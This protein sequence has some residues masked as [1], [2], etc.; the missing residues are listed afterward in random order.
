MHE[1]EKKIE[2]EIRRKRRNNIIIKDWKEKEGGNV[3]L[4]ENVENIFKENIHRE[5]K[6]LRHKKLKFPYAL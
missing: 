6:Q 4:K 5:Q 2:L 3:R 1:F